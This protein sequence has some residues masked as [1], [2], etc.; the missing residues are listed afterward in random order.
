M[1][2]AILSPEQHGVFFFL[3]KVPRCNSWASQE[4][5]DYLQGRRSL[6]MI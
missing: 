6:S 2:K 1:S 3:S 4:A 5:L